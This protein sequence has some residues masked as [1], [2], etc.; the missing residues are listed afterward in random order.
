MPVPAAKTATPRADHIRRD[1]PLDAGTATK[2]LDLES[3]PSCSLIC[4]YRLWN[5]EHLGYTVHGDDVNL[6]AR[7]EQLNKDFDSSILVSDTTCQS[8]GG[9]GR[10]PFKQ[11]GE[12]QV[13]GKTVL[14]T[15]YTL[16]G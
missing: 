3:T 7:L 14:V 13:R 1:L 15:I 10:F 12:A 2:K 11:I 8:A 16:R 6:A 9:R 5:A 4:A